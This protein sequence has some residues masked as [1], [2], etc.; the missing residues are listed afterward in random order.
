MLEYLLLR[1]EDSILF[2]SGL[3]KYLVLDEA[4]TY[5]GA[6]GIEIAMLVRRLKQRLSKKSGDM[7]CIATSATLVNDEVEVAVDFAKH[8]FGED[9]THGDI[10]FGETRVTKTD[11]PP[12]VHYPLSEEVYLHSDFNKLIEE[13]RRENPSVEDIALWMNEIGLADDS[14]PVSYTH[15]RA[16]ET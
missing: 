15:L 1:P 16:H 2:Q 10:I 11:D 4:H 7:I 9:F 5:S 14:A 13:L 12:E 8:L 3:W 6:Q